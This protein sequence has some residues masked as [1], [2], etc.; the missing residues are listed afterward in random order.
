MFTQN[1]IG[2]NEVKLLP[3]FEQRTVG[4]CE[5][6]TQKMDLTLQV[7]LLVPDVR[8]TNEEGVYKRV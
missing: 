5:L 2:L 8:R 7:P 4:R 6:K 1:F 3:L